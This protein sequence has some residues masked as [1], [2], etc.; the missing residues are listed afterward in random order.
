MNE[1]GLGIPA[2]LLTDPY[3]PLMWWRGEGLTLM[4]R[5]CPEPCFFHRIALLFPGWAVLV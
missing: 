3:E 1:N 2:R 5:T 4:M